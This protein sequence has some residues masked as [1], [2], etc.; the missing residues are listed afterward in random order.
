MIRRDHSG[1][2]HTAVVHRTLVCRRL[3]ERCAHLCVRGY[4]GGG[5]RFLG[6]G[7][8]GG[9][10]HLAVGGPI[11]F[12]NAHGTAEIGAA[13]L[14]AGVIGHIPFVAELEHRGVHRGGRA[15]RHDYALVLPWAERTV[16]SGVLDASL[17]VRFHAGGRARTGLTAVVH[18]VIGVT[19]TEHPCR[20]K[21]TL[22]TIR[23]IVR[24]LHGVEVRRGAISLGFGLSVRGAAGCG[25]LLHLDCEL[26]AKSTKVQISG[27]ILVHK[28]CRID[29]F[30]LG[31]R[32]GEQ[33]LTD[34]ILP[35]AERTLRLSH[36]DG[37]R[38]LSGR[39]RSLVLHRYVVVEPIIGGVVRS[40]VIVG[41][42]LASVCA[43]TGSP[44]E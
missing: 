19:L 27:A 36:A 1:L 17:I 43:I 34:G 42:N 35:R 5:L 28:E 16:R 44:A 25:V 4:V 13:F 26:G 2:Q 22:R 30:N 18:V 11:D 6:L 41:H 32:C 40:A 20:L 21:E 31:L 7:W 15:R 3:G 23:V 12:I 29:G 10:N 33:R 38:V 37:E 9:G 39:L 8:M 14:V 24:V